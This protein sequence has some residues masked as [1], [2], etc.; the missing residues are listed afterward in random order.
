MNLYPLDTIRVQGLGNQFCLFVSLSGEKFWNQHI[1]YVKGLLYMAVTW[2]SKRN[3]VC[4]PDRDQS[5]SLLCISSS[6]LFN[7]GIVHHFDT[8]NRLDTVETGH[9][10][11]PSTCSHS[12]ASSFPGL[13]KAGQGPWNKATHSSGPTGEWKSYGV[14]LLTW[15]LLHR[16][17]EVGQLFIC[18]QHQGVWQ[19]GTGS[20]GK[21]KNPLIFHPHCRYPMQYDVHYY[22]NLQ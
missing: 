16:L 9:V 5:S 13:R 18:W 15:T 14:L 8:V 6:F 10:L 17:D 21:Y 22:F 2:Q 1:Y 7:V 12:P 3:N 11:T 19:A 20:V 4:V